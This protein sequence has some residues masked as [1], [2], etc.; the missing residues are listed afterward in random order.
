MGK[1]IFLTSI[2]IPD[3]LFLNIYKISKVAVRLYADYHC[4]GSG[5]HNLQLYL[6]VVIRVLFISSLNS[7]LHHGKRGCVL[8]I[9][10]RDSCLTRL[11]LRIRVHIETDLSID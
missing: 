2:L 11:L 1:H 4:I 5:L 3:S 10:N 7:G 8:T 9:I 6:A